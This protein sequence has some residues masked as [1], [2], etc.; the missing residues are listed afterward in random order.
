MALEAKKYLGPLIG[1]AADRKPI[2]ASPCLGSF[3]AGFY[4]ALLIGV[5][6]DGK[7]IVVATPRGAV[8]TGYYLAELIGVAADGKPI[9][10]VKTCPPSLVSLCCPSTG[11]LPSLL[12]LTF[13]V[14]GASI[15]PQWTEADGLSLPANWTP[16]GASGYWSFGGSDF[17]LATA[18]AGYYDVYLNAVGS[19]MACQLFGGTYKLLVRVQLDFYHAGTLCGTVVYSSALDP[20]CTTFATPGSGD[21]FGTRAVVDAGCWGY[22]AGFGPV[23]FALDFLV[24]P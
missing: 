23:P 24:G 20:D 14:N 18:I 17:F 3:Q 13:Y 19:S 4:D 10:A 12:Y 1:V 16:F 15:N 5:A 22:G 7:P 6:A 2:Q 8:T 11:G 21:V 9:A